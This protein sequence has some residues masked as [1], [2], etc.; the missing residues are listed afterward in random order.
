MSVVS[1]LLSF[2]WEARFVPARAVSSFLYAEKSDALDVSLPRRHRRRR[3][4]E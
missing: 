1:L 4:S 2:S 3:R